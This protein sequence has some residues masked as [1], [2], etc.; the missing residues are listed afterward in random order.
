MV[1]AAARMGRLPELAKY[2]ALE[3]IGHG[4]MATV[5]RARDKRLGREVALKV[6]HPHLRNSV[7]VA[8]RF[9][10][11]AKAVAKLRHPSIVE[12]YDVS[13]VTEPDQY[14]VVELVRGMTLR[15]LLRLESEQGRGAMPPE[16]AAAVALE[17]LS[18]LAHANACGVVHRDVKPENVLIEHRA[19][20][21][22]GA[23]GVDSGQSA[24]RV[25]V[26]LTDFGIA[27][28]LDAQGVTSTGQVLG[29]P[30][31][32]APEQIEGGEVDARSDVFGLGVLLYECMVGQLPFQGTNPAQVLRRV[33]EGQYPPAFSSRPLV[34]ARW[35]AILDRALAHAPADRFP[36]A[37]AVADAIREELERLGFTAPLRELAAWLDDPAAYASANEARIIEKLR[38]LGDDARKRRDMVAAANDYNRALAY[39]PDDP[40]LMRIVTGLYRA[41]ARARI[42]RRGAFAM[43]MAACLGIGLWAVTLVRAGT[44][45]APGGARSGM[46]AATT[47]EPSARTS[48]ESSAVA[49]SNG[50]PSRPAAPLSGGAQQ[51]GGGAAPAAATTAMVSSSAARP[52][53]RAGDVAV[54]AGAHAGAAS[55]AHDALAAKVTERTFTLDLKPPMGVDVAL[56]GQPARAVSSGD[57]LT[58]DGNAHELVFSCP[59]CAPV[60]VSVAAGE[61]DD[62]L[63][64]SVP[65]KPATLVVVGNAAKTYQIAQHPEL[66]VRAG[67]NT[68]T[69]KSAFE[70]VT[71]KEI[72]SGTVVSVRLEAGKSVRVSFE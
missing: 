58:L 41:E 16:V 57:A 46:P 22:A 68:L 20:G 52:G 50:S 13:E 62:R 30:A 12:V 3:E 48:A 44:A 53:D 66:S 1:E 15:Q 54:S 18:A 9:F 8:S 63:V 64:V 11:E 38:A 32:M 24:S 35:S 60:D 59:V 51:A 33:L 34:G 4:G 7:E 70:H 71:V 47:V 37:S 26:K 56:D 45:G 23:D 43:G 61:K 17:V 28:L 65:I 42:A 72:E 49:E 6:I 5:Y 25:A 39:A 14:L 29:S 31:H 69:L 2:E 10:A 27:K 40:Q 21:G 19:P 36:N 55:K 67:T